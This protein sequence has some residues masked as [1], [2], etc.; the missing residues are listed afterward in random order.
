M[1]EVKGRDGVIVDDVTD[2][3]ID[4]DVTVDVIVHAEGSVRR[5]LFLVSIVDALWPDVDRQFTDAYFDLDTIVNKVCAGG[6]HGR[7]R[8]SPMMSSRAIL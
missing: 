4:D 2:D 6:S 5:V 1:A 7:D 8:E 3:I